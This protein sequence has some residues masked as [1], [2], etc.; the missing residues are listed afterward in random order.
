MPL[1]TESCV[2]RD[3]LLVV[4]QRGIDAE[5][6]FASFSAQ[7]NDGTNVGDTSVLMIRPWTALRVPSPS[8]ILMLLK[9]DAVVMENSRK[10]LRWQTC[11]HRW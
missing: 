3:E 9:S 11:R 6:G 2:D 1:S 4:P 7:N 5:K 8:P 10:L